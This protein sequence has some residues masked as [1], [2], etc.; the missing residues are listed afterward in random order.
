[1]NEF[2]FYLFHKIFPTTGINF[3]NAIQ[4]GNLLYDNYKMNSSFLYRL[5]HN[6]FHHPCNWLEHSNF[7]IISLHSNQN[8][9]PYQRHANPYRSINFLFHLYL[10]QLFHLHLQQHL[11]WEEQNEKKRRKKNFF[12]LEKNFTQSKYNKAM[13]KKT[14]K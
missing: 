13:K 10:K 3:P 7:P 6:Q 11:E 8:L 12:L 4:E 2:F 14:R 9:Y 1:M 5:L